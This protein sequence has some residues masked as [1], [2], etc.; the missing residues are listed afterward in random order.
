MDDSSTTPFFRWPTNKNEDEAVMEDQ[1]K[2]MMKVAGDSTI[3]NNDSEK[4][5]PELMG[6]GAV[7]ATITTIAG[8]YAATHMD[9]RY[10]KANDG[11]LGTFA[12]HSLSISPTFPLTD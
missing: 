6:A 12:L 5:S 2:H 7:A 8:I 3:S 9:I 10:G 1:T 11:R 4:M